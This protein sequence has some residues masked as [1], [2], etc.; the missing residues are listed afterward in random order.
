MDIRNIKAGLHR[1]ERVQQQQPSE[2]GQVGG[3]AATQ[4]QTP[5]AAPQNDSVELSPATKAPH[6]SDGPQGIDFARKALL[7]VPP[8]SQDRVQDILKRVQEGY[9]SQPEVVKEIAT[10]ITEDLA[11]SNGDSGS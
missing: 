8:L 7:G 10:R 6:G 3:S 9:Y 2:S 5:A 1:I 4:Q 11:G